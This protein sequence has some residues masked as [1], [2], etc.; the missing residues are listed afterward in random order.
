MFLTVVIWFIIPIQI[1]V[2]NDSAAGAQLFPKI[3]IAAMFCLSVII[4]LRSLIGKKDKTIEFDLKVEWE[5]ALYALGIILYVIMLDLTGFIISTLL[6]SMITLWI[7]KSRRM[8]YLFMVLFVLAV[9][10]L[11]TLVLGI[12][13]P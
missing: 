12:I 7:F 13:L 9:Y 10:F 3:I 5:I 11:F 1:S 6:F 8:V 2:S 4:F